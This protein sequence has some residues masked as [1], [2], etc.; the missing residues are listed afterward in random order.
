MVRLPITGIQKFGVR[1]MA[2]FSSRHQRITAQECLQGA[3]SGLAATQRKKRNRGCFN[4]GFLRPDMSGS[5][6]QRMT[7]SRPYRQNVRT[8]ANGKMGSFLPFAADLIDVRYGERL[9]IGL[10]Y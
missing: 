9:Q 1:K 4:V 6:L 10:I 2:G 5:H 8:A 3:L 7:G